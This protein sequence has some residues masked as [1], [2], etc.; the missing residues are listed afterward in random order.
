MAC[1][2]WHVEA[3][4]RPEAPECWRHLNQAIWVK[5][6]EP[7]QNNV[8]KCEQRIIP[9]QNT[10][11]LLKL[12]HEWHTTVSVWARRNLRRGRWLKMAEILMLKR[13]YNHCQSREGSC[14]VGAFQFSPSRL[15]I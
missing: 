3:R 6:V 4:Q 2:R 7:V 12:H 14:D 10:L 5:S 1:G 11:I 13:N 9:E 8:N 15:Q